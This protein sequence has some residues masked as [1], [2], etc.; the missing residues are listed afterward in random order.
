MAHPVAPLTLDRLLVVLPAPELGGAE[1]VALRQ[2]AGLRARGTRV[3]VLADRR[4]GV[5]SPGLALPFAHDP[6]RPAAEA[7]AGQRA[8]LDALLRRRRWDAALVHCPLPGEGLGALEALAAAGVPALAHHHL[9]RRDLELPPGERT[10]LAALPGGFS[11]VSDPAAARL[12]ALLGRPVAVLGNAAPPPVARVPAARPY[13][14]FLGRL[15]GR[16]GA[17]LLPA[18]ARLAAPLRVVAAGA[19]PLAGTL[20]PAEEAGFV[21]DP[22][23]LLAG[24]TALLMLGEHEG[25]PLAALE[26][27]AAGCPVV[28]RPEAMEAWAG[29]PWWVPV[30]RDP[31]AIAAALR[32]P[33]PRPGPGALAPHAEAP[34]LDR[35]EALLL[36]ERAR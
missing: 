15:D 19:G 6:H 33:L 5:A 18:V 3:E 31:A 8:L 26:A 1:R 28:G 17:D 21:A 35:L 14:L 10:A 36:A 20:A 2:A 29:A 24:A 27:L 12:G 13:A 11:A 9:V 34:L 30:G 22:R 25:M 32:R 7:R 16:K 23:P 4:L